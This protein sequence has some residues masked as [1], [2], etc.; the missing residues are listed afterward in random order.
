MPSPEQNEPLG[1]ASVF[2]LRA[3]VQAEFERVK[4]DI[5]RI[6]SITTTLREEDARRDERVLHYQRI[7][8]DISI[9]VGNL[10]QAT[11]RLKHLEGDG[12]YDTLAVELKNFKTELDNDDLKRQ[13]GELS[14]PL[15]LRSLSDSLQE[16]TR[17]D[18]ERRQTTLSDLDTQKKKVE[19]LEKTV[20]ELKIKVALFATII[21]FVLVKGSELLIHFFNK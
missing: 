4:G 13:I 14:G 15:S 3:Y 1:F 8:D 5:V 12:F 16:H 7:V 19:T 21:S 18:A 9:R 17:L 2:E 20:T 6:Y 10:S 11:E